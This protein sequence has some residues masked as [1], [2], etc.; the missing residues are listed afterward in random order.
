MAI[1]KSIRLARKGYKFYHSAKKAGIKPGGFFEDVKT[2]F[3]MLS[4]YAKGNYKGLRKRSI[5]KVVAGGLYLV[6]FIDLIPDFIPFIGWADDVAVLFFIYRSLKKEIDL[7]K[8]WQQQP[9]IIHL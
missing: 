6:S 1:L 7:F 2:L 3:T 5:I 8:A 9:K 4:E